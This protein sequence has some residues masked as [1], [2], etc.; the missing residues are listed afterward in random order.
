MRQRGL[1]SYNYCMHSVEHGASVSNQDIGRGF[2][3]IVRRA[4]HSHGFFVKK[5]D[6]SCKLN[7]RGQPEL[8]KSQL[9]YLLIA[10]GPMVG[11]FDCKTFQRDHFTY[12]QINRD[13]LEQ[14]ILFNERGVPA[15]FIVLFTRT[16]LVSYF[17]GFQIDLKGP[18]Q[19][20]APG[21]GTALG[22]MEDFNLHRLFQEMP[23]RTH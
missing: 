16:R 13:Q 19:H 6:L 9:D 3:E 17:T 14:A 15:G 11:F 7:Y 21:D 18:R 23:A 10:P 20:F 22:L 4:A 8:T 5:N 12:S 1:M 2:E